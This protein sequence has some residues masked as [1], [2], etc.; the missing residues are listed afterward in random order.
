[1]NGLQPVPVLPFVPQNRIQIGLKSD[2]QSYVK[3]TYTWESRTFSNETIDQRR[4]YVEEETM[5]EARRLIESRIITDDMSQLEIAKALHKWVVDR[6]DY[7]YALADT[8]YDSY[9]SLREGKSVCTGYADLY[10]RMLRIFG[11]KAEG[12]FGYVKSL[13]LIHI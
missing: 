5:N 3:V 10:N 4:A 9:S 13:S 6:V 11:I 8:S 7:D 2:S 1:M 12:I